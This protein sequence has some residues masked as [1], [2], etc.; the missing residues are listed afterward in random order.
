VTTMAGM[1]QQ[2]TSFDQNISA[3]VIDQVSNFLNFMVGAT[4][5]TAN[6]D[7][8]LIAW[9]AQ[10][11]LNPSATSIDFGGSKYTSTN[12]TVVTARDTLV[13]HFASFADGGAA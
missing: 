2:A 10:A 5:S 4:L 13:T 12:P 3:W 6:Y 9:A 11:P 1:F 7:D 8:L